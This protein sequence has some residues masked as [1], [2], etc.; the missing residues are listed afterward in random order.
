LL[1][2][3]SQKNRAFPLKY[4]GLMLIRQRMDMSAFGDENAAHVH[5]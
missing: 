5:V 2:A 3:E 4:R 1:R